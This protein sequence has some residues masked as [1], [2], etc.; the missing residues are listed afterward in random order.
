[1]TEIETANAQEITRLYELGI[2]FVPSLDDTIE[3]AFEKA[4]GVITN[5]GGSITAESKP[6]LIQLAYTMVKN[7]DSKNKKY[8]TAYFGWI[9]FTGAPELVADVKEALDVNLDILRYMIIKTDPEATID[10]VDVAQAMSGGKDAVIVPDE[11]DVEVAS[12]ADEDEKADDSDDAVAEDSNAEASEESEVDGADDDLTAVD[13][14]I[15]ELVEEEET[16]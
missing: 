4:K 14:A 12:D 7:I 3:A 15:D 10:A 16:K 5:S 1:M 2:N 6:A 8:D 11:E 9:K 13:A